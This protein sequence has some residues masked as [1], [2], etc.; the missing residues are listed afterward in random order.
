MTTPPRLRSDLTVSRQQ[1]V[2]GSFSIVKDPVSGHFFR[3]RE[4][5]QF[6]V[7]QLDGN[8]TLDVVRRRTEA[9]FD[10]SLSADQLEAFVQRLEKAGLLDSGRDPRGEAK[11]KRLRGTWLYMRWAL[12]DPDQLLD[13]L[14][15]RVRFLFTARFVVFSAAA[16]LLATATLFFNWSELSQDLTR[17]YR[18]SSIPLLVVVLFTVAS[19]H[20]F[21]HGLTCKYFGGHVHEMGFLLMYFQPAL[22][23]NVSDA[24]L[25][26]ER[27]QR[28]WVGVAGPWFELFL[29][30]L[31][32]LTWRLTDAESGVHYLALAVT[33]VSGI[34][35]LFNF[36]PLLKLDG[37][38]LLSDYLDIPNL[39]KRSF[40]YVGD[41]F[42]RA[43]GLGRKVT[44]V[45][46]ARERRVYVAYGLVATVMSVGVL[47][48]VVVKAGGFLIERH[49][50]MALALFAGL[51]ASKSR[52]RFRKLF[53]K[54][55]RE[56]P[57]GALQ[58][59]DV[60][61]AEPPTESAAVP[62]A[63]PA[64]ATPPLTEKRKPSSGYRRRIIWGALGSVA[65]AVVLLGRMQL[66]IG[67]AF[68]VLPEE[69]ADVRAQ[70]DGLIEE[71]TVTEGD[72]VQAGD[73]IARLS[74]HALLAE[75]QKTGPA[76]RETRAFLSKLEAGPTPEEIAV[77]KAAVGRVEDRLG[78]AQGNAAR[79]ASLFATAAVTRQ[80]L[81][82]AQEAAATAENELA[83]ARSRLDLLLRRSRPEDIEASRAR[84]A[85]LETQQRF[86]NGEVGEL[87]VVSPVSGVVA[88]PARQLKEMR[89]QLVSRGALIAKI[90]D[91]STV[92]A[93]IVVSEKDIGDV[94]V[95][96]PVALRVRAYPSVVFQGTVTAIATA[97]DGTPTAAAQTPAAGAGTA[98]AGSASPGKTF[99]VT[100]RI[101]NRDALLKPGMTGWAKISGG[102]KRIASLFTRRL[103][104]TFRVE[105]WSWW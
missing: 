64:K 73:V 51:V 33:A 91:F 34:K 16:I 29:W 97:A 37:Y 50:P 8:T 105:V 102:E 96:E 41:L 23:T 19:A 90:Y 5:E 72:R 60:A 94:R 43:A 14:V 52:R 93:Q 103:A 40:A 84:L 81:E 48:Y 71:I 88:T 79:M 78:F 83:E 11:K 46:S 100:T 61:V 26:R 55:P 38:Y 57:A 32:L 39:R 62:T 18:I 12:F 21:A 3:F 68:T 65:L 92:M 86:L 6:I 58:S 20:E 7:E 69:N 15:H 98:A 36:N 87:T 74:N 53:G 95:G 67:G 101:D 77:A 27:R 17:L 54:P 4:T 76:I 35:T 22:Y 2:D 49:Q 44:T 63:E 89:H 42:S 28:L 75:L 31:A 30:A 45:I 104:R 25:F 99:I 47:A 59:G 66:R 82:A 1:A 13:R 80:E 10:A 70:V 24:W 85:L 9:R 56:R